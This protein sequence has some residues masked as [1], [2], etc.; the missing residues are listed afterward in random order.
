MHG[1]K[2]F[3]NRPE[4]TFKASRI[5]LQC[6]TMRSVQNQP[7]REQVQPK[8]E[9]TYASMPDSRPT[10]RIL[11]IRG[12][13]AAHGGFETFAEK[14]A[15]Y[16]V[17]KGWRIIVYCQELGPRGIVLDEWQGIE[18]VRIAVPGEGALGTM[19]FDLLSILHARKTKDPCLTLG[20]NTACFW[21]LLRFSG[22][23]NIANMDG[24]EWRRAKWSKPV[25][26]WFW[27]ND[28]FGC[29]TA[30]HLIA[31]HPEIKKL[32]LRRVR[33][34]KVTQIAY[35]ADPSNASSP[36]PLAQ[37]GLEPGQFMT[38]IARPEP[39]NSVLECIAGFSR[40]PRG[41][42]LVVLGEYGESHEYHQR[43]KAAASQEVA[44]LGAIY[45][46]ATVAALRGH[47]LAYLHGHQVGGTN[48]SL[49]E[50]LGAGNA[51]VA[52]DNC[53]NRWVTD[54]RAL[55]F[56][57]VD[58]AD[59]AISRIIREPQLREEMEKASG[60][61]FERRF[62]WRRILAE[63]EAVLTREPRSAHDVRP[64][65]LGVEE[66]REAKIER[67]VEAEIAIR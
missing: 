34:D 65:Q 13:P 17:A 46:K 39:E 40:K 67:D 1:K 2:I 57:D 9:L 44:F 18:R 42:K 38:L 52:H 54:E 5:P 66:Q 19:H 41:L 8:L 51:I 62:S 64:V 25:K 27:L 30:N 3:G 55:Y 60:R 7:R 47:C 45:D 10:L 58:G 53:F 28:W 33:A 21:P 14:L 15:L 22:I 20:Y 11:G 48:P 4:R 35:G 61:L 56:S 16:L 12:I 32:L 24:V 37:Y 6:L 63:Y 50:A 49:I 36:E 31:D 59:M 43:V 29:W 23:Y 26:A